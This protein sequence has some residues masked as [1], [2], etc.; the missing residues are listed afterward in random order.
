MATIKATKEEI[1]RVELELTRWE[2]GAIMALISSGYTGV[3]KQ[4]RVLADE[5]I[6]ALRETCDKGGKEWQA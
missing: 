1:I 2:R 3:C 6:K 4:E 5:F